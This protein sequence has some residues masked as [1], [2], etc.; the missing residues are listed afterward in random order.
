MWHA[1]HVPQASTAVDDQLRAVMRQVPDG[2]PLET[3]VTRGAVTEA[4]LSMGDAADA[5]VVIL[6]AHEGKTEDHASVIEF[7]LEHSKRAVLALHDPKGSAVLPRFTATHNEM[8]TV[9]VPANPASEAH[10]QIEFACDLARTV[11]VKLHLLD[12]IEPRRGATAG[13]DPISIKRRVE[14]LVPA[15]LVPRTT[16][17]VETGDAVAAISEWADRLRASLIVMGEHT[18]VPVK[19]WLTRDTSRAILHRVRCPVWYVPAS[20]AALALSLDR[21]ALSS[22][23]SILWGNV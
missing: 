10:P 5:D 11:P 16:V 19:R 9:L 6:T 3:C 1:D 17:H 22:E 2:V 15:D 7:L 13:A 20:N 21:F 12:V 23:K 4:V 8:Q 18:R 14:S